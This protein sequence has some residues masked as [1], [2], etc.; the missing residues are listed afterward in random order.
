MLIHAASFW[1]PK[2]GNSEKE[3]EDAVYLQGVSEVIGRRFKCAIADGSS[4]GMLSGAWAR[5]VTRRWYRDRTSPTDL[6]DVFLGG[7][8]SDWNRWTKYYKR[9]RYRQN[10][11]LKWYEE[12]GLGRGAFSTLLG[13]SLLEEGSRWE[14]V[15]VGDSCLF[16]VRGEQMVSVFPL[17]HSSDFGNSPLLISSNPEANQDLRNHIKRTKGTW[18]VN[19]VFYLMTDALAAWCLAES[20]AHRFLH[21]QK[22]RDLDTRDEDRSFSEWVGDLRQSQQIRNDD[23]TLVRIDV[24]TEG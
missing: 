5:V 11:P 14:A 2:S 18:Q 8:Y 10:K 1:L 23:V 13:F 9:Y 7:I 16:Q 4:E 24:M 19:D 17:E 12:H 20:E 3:Y 6:D 21:W 15:T 22:F